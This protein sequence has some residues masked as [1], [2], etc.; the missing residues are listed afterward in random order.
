MQK[1]HYFK[2][3]LFTLLLACLAGCDKV[4]EA[5]QPD[6]RYERRIKKSNKLVTDNANRT[7]GG[8]EDKIK[9]SIVYF[10]NSNGLLNQFNIYIDTSSNAEL[11]AAFNVMYFT[12]IILVSNVLVSDVGLLFYHDNQKRVKLIKPI[13]GIDSIKF[14]Y[15]NN[16]QVNE[17]FII[18]SLGILKHHY[19]FV[20]DGSNNLLS[21][22]T[23]ERNNNNLISTIDLEYYTSYTIRN[24][25]D[26]RFYR[27]ETRIF[28]LGGL[29]LI[30]MI[31]LNYGETTK[32]ALKKRTEI[33]PDIDG[34]SA[35]VINNFSY[36]FNDQNE[37]IYRY[38]YGPADTLRYN[39]EYED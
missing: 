37:I 26:S 2:F 22:K 34:G 35:T 6:G 27:E 1:T 30:Y 4:N 13:L 36:D 14:N 32:N 18:D 17:I 23:K 25:F 28:H 20:Y 15:N 7:K 16:N 21:Y 12:N 9:E 39:F 10:Y 3:L 29:N 24:E 38:L 11:L 33:I 19:D 8:K 5:T 31:G